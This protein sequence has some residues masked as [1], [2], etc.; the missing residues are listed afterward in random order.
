M[1]EF[2]VE[3]FTYFQKLTKYEALN[4]PSEVTTLAPSLPELL[5]AAFCTDAGQMLSSICSNYEF[6]R[7]KI[8]TCFQLLSVI[9][10]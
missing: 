5:S 6:N 3:A 9:M 10:I 1:L 4:E 7:W 2:Q 8:L